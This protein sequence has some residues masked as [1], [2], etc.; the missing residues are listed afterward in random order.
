MLPITETIY[1]I[2]SAR[3]L[4]GWVSICIYQCCRKSNFD[5]VPILLKSD[6]VIQSH[7]IVI[8]I[9]HIVA[10][11]LKHNRI[12]IFLYFPWKVIYLLA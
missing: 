10:C 5:K 11:P 4:P 8:P 2:C 6:G 1:S 9:K 7:N 12:K 3:V